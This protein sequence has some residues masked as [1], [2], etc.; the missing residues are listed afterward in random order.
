MTNVGQA[1]TVELANVAAPVPG[2]S[3]RVLGLIAVALALLSALATFL[4]LANLTPILPTHEVVLTL[5]A[6]N[7]FTAL[8]LLGIIAYE[9]WRVFQARRRGRAGARLHVRIV[10]LFSVSAV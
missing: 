8:F 3:A 4:V 1:A 7:V 2:R 6:V 5:L 10:A 9:V